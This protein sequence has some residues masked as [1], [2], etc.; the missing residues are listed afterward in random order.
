M[1][2]REMVVRTISGPPNHQIKQTK[3]R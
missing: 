2:L 3:P 1:N